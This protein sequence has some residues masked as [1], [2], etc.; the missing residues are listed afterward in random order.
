PLLAATYPSSAPAARIMRACHLA[1]FH[2]M[3]P[4]LGKDYERD[5]ALS[6]NRKATLPKGSEQTVS[7]LVPKAPSP[8]PRSGRSGS[9]CATCRCPGCSRA[10]RLATYL[11][12][13]NNC[14]QSSF[15]LMT[16]QP[17]F[18]ASS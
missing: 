11:S 16:T 4:P 17:R 8:V 2:M 7:F 6:M 10:R 18:F 15:M 9:Q 3:H 1:F 12:N 13:E 14:F 5:L